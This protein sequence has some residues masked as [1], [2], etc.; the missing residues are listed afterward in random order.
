MAC[1]K[2]ISA[3]LNYSVKFDYLRVFAMAGVVAV[4]LSQQFPFPGMLKSIMGMGAYCVQIFYVISAYLGCS[5]FFRKNASCTAYYKKRALRILPTYYAAIVAAMF[6]VEIFTKGYCDDVLH[7]GWLRYFLGLNVILPSNNFYEWNNAFGFW[8]MTNFLFFYAIIPLLIKFAQSFR[9]CIILFLTLFIIAGIS[10]RLAN[11]LPVNGIFSELEW[12]VVWSPLVQMQHFA[13]GMLVFF[14]M[15]ESKKSYACILLLS[16]A[17]CPQR[18][19]NYSL[20]YSIL[21]GLFIMAVRDSDIT[22]Q[23]TKQAYLSF[24]S[25][26]SFHVYLTHLL[27]LK[28]ATEISKLFCTPATF[29]YYSLKIFIAI[30]TT[31]VL[32]C[33]LEIVQR[34]CN[35]Y[36]S[37]NKPHN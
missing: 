10:Q 3:D 18:I 21:T 15:K 32:C 30:L 8:T 16:L 28:I 11:C 35:K 34:L 25:K 12:L 5:F 2:T 9:R 31:F 29:T 1:D 7:L 19:C 36:F 33:F 14:A 24:V 27:A 4:H 37:S 26:Y 13:I 6:Y 17:L 20:L 23:G 22:I